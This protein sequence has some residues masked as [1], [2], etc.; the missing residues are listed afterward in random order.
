MKRYWYCICS[1]ENLYV[2]LVCPSQNGFVSLFVFGL[3]SLSIQVDEV[4]FKSSHWWD[5]LYGKGSTEMISANFERGMLNALTLSCSFQPN[6]A[7]NFTIYN[8]FFQVWFI[9]SSPFLSVHPNTSIFFWTLSFFF[10]LEKQNCAL[11]LARILNCSIFCESKIEH[12]AS[13]CWKGQ[14]S[15]L[16]WLTRWEK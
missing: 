6:T 9:K 2:L 15:L 7:L 8:I 5:P 1:L 14:W 12:N 10:H 13:T 11:I 16:A 4:F 3:S